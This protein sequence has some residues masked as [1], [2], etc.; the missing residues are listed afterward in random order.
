MENKKTENKQEERVV[1]AI[2]IKILDNG[3]G[4]TLDCKI[5]KE[6]TLDNATLGHL[7]VLTAEK[8]IMDD[9]KKCPN[10][11]PRKDGEIG[12]GTVCEGC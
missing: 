6:Q 5:N 4:L 7:L 12:C 2:L 9:M 11:T 1:G 8:L 3:E 10:F